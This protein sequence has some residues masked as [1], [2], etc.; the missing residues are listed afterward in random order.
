MTYRYPSLFLLPLFLV[1]HLFQPA[2]GQEPSSIVAQLEQEEQQSLAALSL[3][4]DSL[5][6][7]ILAACLHPEV[8]I[9]LENMQS[10]SAASFQHIL[11]NYDKQTQEILWDLSRYP[12]LIEGLAGNGQKSTKE[13]AALLESYPEEIHDHAFAYGQNEYKTLAEIYQ[14]NQNMERAFDELLTGYPTATQNTFMTLLSLPEAIGILA[15]NMRMTILVGDLYKRHPESVKHEMDSLNIEIANEK[16][17][18]LEDW[19][20]TLEENPEA[21]RELE[22][23]SEEYAKEYSRA[24]TVQRVEVVHHNVWNGPN[25]YPYRYWYGYPW[26]YEYAHWYP[27]PY[28]YHWGYYYG[29]GG[30]VTIIGLPSWHFC[31]WYFQRPR[32]HYHWY[33]LSDCFAGYHQRHRNSASGLGRAVNNWE[34]ENRNNLPRGWMAESGRP[35]RFR[36]FGKFEMDLEAHNVKHS[37]APISRIEYLRKHK[38]RYPSLAPAIQPVPVKRPTSSEPTRTQP[39]VLPSPK[40]PP[41][42]EPTTRPGWEK[43]K[44]TIERPAP[45]QRTPIPKALDYHQN[46]WRKINPP[47]SRTVTPRSTP[48]IATPNRTKMKPKTS[49]KKR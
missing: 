18:E 7:V 26:W 23:A 39:V 10:R 8:I 35:D 20:R 24:A 22:A 12:G 9:R 4:P 29:P 1:L 3:Y 19:K 40:T 47:K 32:H 17:A 2:F 16:A 34:N 15:D 30:G 38:N 5:R 44:V 33:H 46:N 41:A 48:K 25:W 27:Y 11:A 14:L 43:P 31:N 45:K 49:G 37:G 21:L 28:W 6:D 13:I 42:K 36:E